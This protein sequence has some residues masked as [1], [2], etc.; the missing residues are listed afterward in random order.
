MYSVDVGFLISKIPE[1]TVAE[2]NQTNALIR[3]VKKWKNLEYRIHSFRPN[4]KLHMLCWTDAAW[5]NRPNGKDSTEGIFVGMADERLIQGYEADVSALHWRSSKI[6]RTCRSPACAETHASL[7]GEDDLLYLRVLWFEINGGALDPRDPGH[8]ALQ[9][10]AALV[11]D[12]KNLYDKIHRPTVRVK[13]AEKRSDIQAIALRENLEESET[14]I[15][16]VHGGNMIANSLTKV[17]E[18]HQML[19][20]IQFGFRYKIVYDE[21]KRSERQRRKL[22]MDPFER[23]VKG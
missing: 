23:D 4:S 14:P 21:E 3:Q 10:P 11:T 16:W 18:K 8:A 6:E 20:Y 15:F 9:V 5:A 19:N 17:H 22:G 12:S 2:I 7:D 1:S 13:G